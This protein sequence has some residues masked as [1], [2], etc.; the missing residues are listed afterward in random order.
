M[1]CECDPFGAINN[2]CEAVNGQ[3][4]CKE[5]IE[6]TVCGEV[7]QGYYYGTL[8]ITFDAEDTDSVSQY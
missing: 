5:N 3:C 2:L 6:G 8:D 1:D 4:N 7:S